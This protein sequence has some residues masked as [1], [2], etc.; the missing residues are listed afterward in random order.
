LS[1]KESV[2]ILNVLNNVKNIYFKILKNQF[3]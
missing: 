1:S 3:F 2:A